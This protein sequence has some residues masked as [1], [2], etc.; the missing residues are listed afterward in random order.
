[1]GVCARIRSEAFAE[2]KLNWVNAHLLRKILFFEGGVNAKSLAF[3]RWDSKSKGLSLSGAK[4]MPEDRANIPLSL[5]TFRS[6]A[7]RIF[8]YAKHI[9]SRFIQIFLKKIGR[10]IKKEDYAMSILQ[11]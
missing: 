3:T 11:S 6:E 2:G 7:K 9:Q 4:K 8:F 10:D 5:L 1:M